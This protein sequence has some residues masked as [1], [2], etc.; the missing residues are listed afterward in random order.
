[1]DILKVEVPVNVKYVEGSL[2]Y[3][4]KKAYSLDEAKKH[5]KTA[6]AVAKKPF[7]YLSAGVTDEVFRATLEL[8]AEAGVGFSGVL[9]GRATWQDGIPA[10]G[11]GGAAGLEA[12]LKDRG[13][14]NVEALN[15]VLAK[16]ARPW[17]DFYGGKGQVEV[18]DAPTPMSRD[19]IKR[20]Y[21]GQVKA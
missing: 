14:K 18:V 9:C 1:V 8:A 17:F 2:A 15:Q 13:R 12:W 16:G 4:G 6:A 21:A 10:Y 5:F 3:E 19:E 11:K 7:I 20:T